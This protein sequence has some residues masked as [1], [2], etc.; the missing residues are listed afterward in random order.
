[1]FWQSQDEIDALH[2]FRMDRRKRLE[3]QTDLTD[4]HDIF[5]S[6]NDHNTKAWAR[7][8]IKSL[9]HELHQ[10]NAD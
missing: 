8:M 9:E 10:L 7:R 6:S 4:F 2:R 5:W 3:L 1:M